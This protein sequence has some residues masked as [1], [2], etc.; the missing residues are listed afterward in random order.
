M[1]V[2]FRIGYCVNCGNQ[3][4]VCNH[5]GMLLGAMPGTKICWIVLSN[6]NGRECRIGTI[7]FCKDCDI[8]KVK[9]EDIKATLSS[10]PESGITGNEPEWTDLPIARIELVKE[11]KQ[12]RY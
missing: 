5:R 7:M 2:K 6:S 1:S 3:A 9:I 10:N 11:F 12:E 8:S 4:Y